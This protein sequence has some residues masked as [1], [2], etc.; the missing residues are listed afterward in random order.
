MSSKNELKGGPCIQKYPS[1]RLQSERSCSFCRRSLTPSQN[2]SQHIISRWRESHLT[3]HHDVFHNPSLFAVETG[4]CTI[5]LFVQRLFSTHK[6]SSRFF[7]FRPI[8]AGSNTKCLEGDH[9]DTLEATLGALSKL[10]SDSVN[11]VLCDTMWP[12]CGQERHSQDNE[13]ESDQR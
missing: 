12:I 11:S 2:N 8:L 1:E 10:L 6:Y 9:L 4:I 5:E 7:F 13:I 3:R